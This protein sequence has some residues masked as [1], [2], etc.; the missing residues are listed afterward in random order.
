MIQKSFM[1]F[2]MFYDKYL[3][4]RECIHL[5]YNSHQL[6]TL[7]SPRNL[8]VNRLLSENACVY[9]SGIGQIVSIK[10]SGNKCIGK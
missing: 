6:G 9:H 8:H 5:F 2:L 10:S 3:E 4:H 1:F 7:K